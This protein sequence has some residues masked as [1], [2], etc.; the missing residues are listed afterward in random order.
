MPTAEYLKI[1]DKDI[2][3][4]IKSYKNSKTVKI[5][6]KS[7][8]LYVTKPKRLPVNI[9]LKMIKENEEDIYNKYLK[10][11]SSEFDSVKQWK[12]GEKIYYKGNEYKILRENGL[13]I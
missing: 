4:N 7:N 13:V 2:P 1:K 5:Y 11:I 8:I 10:I 3:V 6:F 12:T 9:V